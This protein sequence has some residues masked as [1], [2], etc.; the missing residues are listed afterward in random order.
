MI[1]TSNEL[2]QR[3]IHAVDGDLGT[4]FDLYFDD[5]SW[6]IRYIVAELGSWFKSKRVLISPSAFAEFDGASLKVHLTR[7]EISD[8]PD[9]ENDK[10]VYLQ[11]KERAEALYAMLQSYNATGGPSL[12][13]PFVPPVSGED[14]QVGGRWNRHLRSARVVTQYALCTEEKTVGQARNLLI[15]DR[16]WMVAY[17]VFWPL[18]TPPDEERLFETGSVVAIEWGVQSMILD[19]ASFSLSR[20][21]VF[22]QR[23]HSNISYEELIKLFKGSPRN[24]AAKWDA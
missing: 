14:V 1:R 5:R 15:D 11:E 20:C 3:P 12:V 16:S 19:S 2:Y 6:N 18:G 17:V 24:S 8:C 10:P 7:K 13:V 4:V 9:N 22:V 21:P 23:R